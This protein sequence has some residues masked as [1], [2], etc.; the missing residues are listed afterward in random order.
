VQDESRCGLLPIFRHRITARG[1]QPLW[2][3]GYCFESLDLYGA[4]EPLTGQS[5]FLELPPLNADAFQL[6]LDHF[7]AVDPSAFHILLL[8]NGAFHKARSLRLPANLGL[9]FLPPYSPELNPIERLGRDLKDWLAPHQPAT[10]DELS[11]LLTTRLQ[12]YTPALPCRP[13]PAFPL[14]SPPSKNSLDTNHTETVLVAAP[15]ANSYYEHIGFTNNPRC[16]VLGREQ[17][18]SS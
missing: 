18:I 15:A 9:L 6:F 11:G 2:P 10:L 12:Q 4:V 13:S 8:D 5:F 17:R 1:V 14:S 16:W 3:A 7:T